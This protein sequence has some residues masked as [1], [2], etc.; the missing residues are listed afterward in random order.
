MEHL[1]S[2]FGT[3]LY[4]TN[5]ALLLVGSSLGLLVGVLPF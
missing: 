2:A 1:F 5:L 3:V 4:P